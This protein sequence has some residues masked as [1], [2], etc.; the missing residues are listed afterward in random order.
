MLFDLYRFVVPA[1]G[2]IGFLCTSVISSVFISHGEYEPPHNKTNKIASAPSEDSDQH[3]HPPSLIRVFVVCM[4]EAPVER[5]AKT[6]IRLGG[7]PRWS[8]SSLGA[9]LLCWFCHEVAHIVVFR[10]PLD[11]GMRDTPWIYCHYFL[12]KQNCSLKCF[13][14]N[15]NWWVGAQKTLLQNNAPTY[16]Q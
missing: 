4:K 3:G 11:G 12:I 14:S 8:E 10:F 16:V 2:H 9:Q 15:L 5:K 1:H 13:T 7:C 6:Q